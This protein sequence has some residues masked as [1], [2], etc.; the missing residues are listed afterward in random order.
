VTSGKLG[1]GGAYPSG[2]TAG[3]WRKSFGAAAFISGEGAPVVAGGGD[4]VL[5]LGRGEGVRGLLEIVG[6]GSSGRSSPGSGGRRRGS[7]G[8]H[9]REGGLRWSGEL[10]AR[11]EESERSGDGRTS[12]AVSGEGT[13]RRQRGRGGEKGGGGSGRGVPWGLA[14]IGG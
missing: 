6:I 5:Q 12:G 14:P 8:I 3:S 2:G 1:G 11:E 4:E 13:A 10:G 7:A 9:V